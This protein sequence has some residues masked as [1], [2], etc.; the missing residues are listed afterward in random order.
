MDHRRLA[1]VHGALAS[2]VRLRIIDLISAHKEMCVCEL[3]DQLGMS[4]AN[5]SRHVSVLRDAGVLLDRKVGTW[6]LLRVDEA[7]ISAV[8]EELGAAVGRNHEAARDEDAVRRLEGRCAGESAAEG[9]TVLRE[10][11]EA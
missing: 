4:Q 5:L 9:A 8:A 3:V 10:V 1:R 7:A 6:V 11:A 2:E